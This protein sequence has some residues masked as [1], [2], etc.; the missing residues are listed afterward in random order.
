MT[1]IKVPED[2]NTGDIHKTTIQ[3]W[4][5]Y[6]HRLDLHK[7]IEVRGKLQTNIDSR[8]KLLAKQEETEYRNWVTQALEKGAGMAYKW[9]TQTDKAP[10]LPES[11]QE[12]YTVHTD[13]IHKADYYRRYWG[14]K[15][16][17]DG[18]KFEDVLEALRHI[19]FNSYP[20][21]EIT[22][23]MLTMGPSA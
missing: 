15:W 16:G 4:C 13:P 14:A 18:E 8:G 1:R 10:P 23:D 20:L 5:S 6:A 11:I 7:L 3:G 9:T 2:A 22:P 19:R 17:R 21:D 12:G